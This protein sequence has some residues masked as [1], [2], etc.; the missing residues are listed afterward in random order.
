M[1][2]VAMLTRTW[3]FYSEISVFWHTFDTKTARITL[4]KKAVLSQGKRAMPQFFLV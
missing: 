1:T 2:R 4:N 3:R